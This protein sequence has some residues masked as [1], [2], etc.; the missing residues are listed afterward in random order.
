MSDVEFEM[1][2]LNDNADAHN[3]SLSSSLLAEISLVAE[4]AVAVVAME[5][6]VESTT[7]KETGADQ[8]PTGKKMK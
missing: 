5:T 6:E 4:E 8:T 7:E 3:Y 1:D 2:N